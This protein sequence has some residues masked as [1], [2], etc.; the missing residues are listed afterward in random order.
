MGGGIVSL[1]Y[2]SQTASGSASGSRGAQAIAYLESIG[3]RQDE[4]GFQ[5]YEGE[6][7][8]TGAVE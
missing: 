5:R 3:R 4:C 7:Q 1:S 8:R 2:A 6:C